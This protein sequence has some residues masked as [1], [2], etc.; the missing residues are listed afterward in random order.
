MRLRWPGCR[1]RWGIGIEC[2]R[3]SDERWRVRPLTRSQL[4]DAFIE[5]NPLIEHESKLPD[6]PLVAQSIRRPRRPHLG[7]FRDPEVAQLPRSRRFEDEEGLA[8]LLITH[9]G[10]GRSFDYEDRWEVD[11]LVYTGRGKHG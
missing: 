9:P 11:A 5:L 7:A 8:V 3:P 6:I 2:S 10:G 4:L 1:R